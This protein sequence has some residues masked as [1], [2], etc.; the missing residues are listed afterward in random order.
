MRPAGYE[1]Y[2]YTPFQDIPFETDYFSFEERFKAYKVCLSSV[3]RHLVKG[4]ID[5]H[6]GKFS[7]LVYPF[8]LNRPAQNTARKLYLKLLRGRIEPWD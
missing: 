3:N 5:R 8:A 6:L 2:S 1:R 7:P 4:F